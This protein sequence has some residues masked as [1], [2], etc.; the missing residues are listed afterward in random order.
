MITGIQENDVSRY[1]NIYNIQKLI[2]TERRFDA[3]IK[4]LK[5]KVASKIR[6]EVI[7][8]LRNVGFTETPGTMIEMSG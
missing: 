2:L 7:E 5:E 6:T 3:T 8:P 1:F 4:T